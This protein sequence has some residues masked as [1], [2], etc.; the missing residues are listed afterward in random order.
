MRAMNIIIILL[1]VNM[2]THHML[3]CKFTTCDY[4]SS[5]HVSM[6]DTKLNMQTHYMLIYASSPHFTMHIPTCE[7]TIC[8]VST[9]LYCCHY[10]HSTDSFH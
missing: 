8:E 6:Q 9:C 10:Q 2:L 5:S 3:A 1:H 4:A 7:L